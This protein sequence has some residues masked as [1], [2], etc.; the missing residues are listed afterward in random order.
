METET[1]TKLT[2]GT[3]RTSAGYTVQKVTDPDNQGV[4]AGWHLLDPTGEWCNT[5]TTNRDAVA[6]SV[7]IERLAA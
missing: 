3:Y 6:A 1:T 7:R 5:Y 2:A 4:G